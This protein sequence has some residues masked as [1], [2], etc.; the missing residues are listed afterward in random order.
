[1]AS[2]RYP[3]LLSSTI[4]DE[5]LE[6]YQLL[7]V[8]WLSEYRI[9]ALQ[10]ALSL[11]SHLSKELATVICAQCQKK[12][13]PWDEG[14][15]Q[16]LRQ[17]GLAESVYLQLSPFI[18]HHPLARMLVEDRSFRWVNILRMHLTM[19]L[20]GIS[21]T[22]EQLTQLRLGLEWMLGMITSAGSTPDLTS[23]LTE[24]ACL[25]DDGP[26]TRSTLSAVEEQLEQLYHPA[27]L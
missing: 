14:T 5:A 27:R 3:H 19:R 4:D 20:K 13:T 24:L 16:I 17:A 7:R 26:E 25:I 23:R 11:N 10:Y 1:M 22:R 2:P 18:H 6:A 12:A 15:A 21:S 9:G 8:Q